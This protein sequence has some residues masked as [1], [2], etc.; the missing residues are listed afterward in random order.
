[1][2]HNVISLLVHEQP[3]VVIDQIE[4]IQKFNPSSVIVLHI[5]RF[6]DGN[7][8]EIVNYVKSST[9]VLIN[10]VSLNVAWADIIQAHNANFRFAI[11]ELGNEFD[12]FCIHASNDLFVKHGVENYV[13]SHEC[14][15]NTFKTYKDMQW[16]PRRRA[17]HDNQLFA[18]LKHINTDVI[19]CSQPEGT[20]YHRDL[21]LEIVNIIET[22]F[23]RTQIMS[24]TTKND[25]DHNNTLYAREEVYYPTIANKLSK[26]ISYP[27]VFSEVMVYP[28]Q[29]INIELVEM[30]R[31]DLLQQECCMERRL[32]E[33]EQKMY[34]NNKVFAIKRVPRILENPVRQYVRGLK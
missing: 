27:Y 3:L 32:F 18:I 26:D 25:N 7:V 22:H 10:R 13:H 17:E 24:Y 34:D 33:K 21:F 11:S 6:F 20:F 12:K 9:N 29:S 4:N 5:N 15:V 8:E 2:K 30:I 16:T 19:C 31:N 23:N 28:R 14:G 1:M